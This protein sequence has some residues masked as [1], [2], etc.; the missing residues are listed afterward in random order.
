MFEYQVPLSMIMYCFNY[1][2][3]AAFHCCVVIRAV[4]SPTDLLRALFTSLNPQRCLGIHAP[5][6]LL[7]CT[8]APYLN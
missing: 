8:L 1:D 7:F 5:L 6:R 3:E 2:W 4:A